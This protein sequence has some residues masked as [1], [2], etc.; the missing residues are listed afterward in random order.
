MINI[1]VDIKGFAVVN[2]MLD[3]QALRMPMAIKRAVRKEALNLISIKPTVSPCT[4]TIRTD[5]PLVIPPPYCIDM[6]IE[7]TSEL[8]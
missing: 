3:K 4:D 8:P 1:K 5:C 6:H 2:Q 7:Q